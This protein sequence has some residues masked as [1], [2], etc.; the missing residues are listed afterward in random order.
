MRP[1]HLVTI[2]VDSLVRVACLID[3]TTSIRVLPV[4]ASMAMH[5]G[6]PTIWWQVYIDHGSKSINHVGQIGYICDISN[7]LL[8]LLHG[9]WHGSMLDGS[10]GMSCVSIAHLIDLDWLTIH[11]DWESG[12]RLWCSLLLWYLP[13]LLGVTRSVSSIGW[14]LPLSLASLCIVIPST[15][16]T[17]LHAWCP[18]DVLSID[19]YV[20]TTIDLG[21]NVNVLRCYVGLGFRW[22][23]IW[24]LVIWHLFY[25]VFNVIIVKIIIARV[26]LFI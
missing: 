22:I 6:R 5:S 7:V 17:C 21:L 8:H 19:V 13:V 3:S 10:C 25:L 26:K 11:I 15:A 20:M 1:I 23:S 12:M 18:L 24:L 9:S 4:V 2:H 16:S 14:A